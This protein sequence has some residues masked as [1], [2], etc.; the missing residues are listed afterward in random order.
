[1]IDTW[2]IYSFLV[3]LAWGFWAFLPK[4]AIRKISTD[5][6]FIYEVIGGCVIGATIVLIWT[7]SFHPLGALLSYTAGL[8][9]YGGVYFY[10]RAAKTDSI[11]IVASIT[12]M[13]PI[14]TVI[15]GIYILGETI[16]ITKTL[17][18]ISALLAIFLINYRGNNIEK[19]DHQSHQRKL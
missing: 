2:V 7:P 18:V 9:S 5:S 16:T 11:G 6:A 17:G 10:I 14:I 1:M 3:F 19:R 15:L 4:L 13:Y 8:F 12:G